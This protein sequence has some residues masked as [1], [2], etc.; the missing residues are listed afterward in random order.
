MSVQKF[1]ENV[2]RNLHA[3]ETSRNSSHTRTRNSGALESFLEEQQTWRHFGFFYQY[4]PDKRCCGSKLPNAIMSSVHK[5]KLDTVPTADLRRLSRKLNVPLII[6]RH[7]PN[8]GNVDGLLD[9]ERMKDLVD[10]QFFEPGT[11]GAPAKIELYRDMTWCEVSDMIRECHTNDDFSAEWLPLTKCR[12]QT[13]GDA[14]FSNVLRSIPKVRHIDMDA[15]LICPDCNE[16]TMLIEASS[17]GKKGH[18]YENTPKDI[19]MTKTLSKKIGSYS[20]LLQHFP[21]DA[22][23]AKS[24]DLTIWNKSSG[25]YHARVDNQSWDYVF[26]EMEDFFDEHA[27]HCNEILEPSQPERRRRITASAY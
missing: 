24:V 18:V 11:D 17:T 26:D 4:C 22:R 23:L 16:I 2:G 20:T 19:Y 9:V 21:G 10:V 3:G 12:R 13:D 1:S 7:D 8:A 25:L 14:T 6:V 15:A 27:K 5:D